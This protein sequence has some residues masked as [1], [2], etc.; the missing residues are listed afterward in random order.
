[1][2]ISKFFGWGRYVDPQLRAEEEDAMVAEFDL[3]DQ[4][5][6]VPNSVK[7]K[8]KNLEAAAWKQARARIIRARAAEFG[9]QIVPRRVAPRVRRTRQRGAGTRSSRA[10]GDSNDAADPEPPRGTLLS[11]NLYD[12]AALADL[13]RVSKKTLQ[14]QYSAAPYTLPSAIQIP[15]ARGPRWTPEAV[16]EWLS[17]RPRHTPKPAVVAPRRKVGRPRIASAIKVV[18]S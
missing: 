6:P 10:S 12:Q 7:N 15:G 2:L 18:Q 5:L 4:G 17:E 13:L 3:V 8:V 1:M 16:E 11:L 9:F 14:N